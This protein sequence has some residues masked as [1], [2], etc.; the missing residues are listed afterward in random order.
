MRPISKGKGPAQLQVLRVAIAGTPNSGKTTLFNALTGTH[1]ETGN[2]P[3]V[4][5]EKKEGEFTTD[6]VRVH[7]VDLPGVYG[8]SAYTTDE[9]I[10]RDFLLHEHPDAVIVVVDATNLTQG[11]LLALQ[12]LQLRVPT[13]V[14]LNMMDQAEREGLEIHL[15][16]LERFLGVPVVPVVAVKGRGLDQLKKRLLEVVNHLPPEPKVPV[17]PAF[18]QVRQ[19]LE[20]LLASSPLAHRYPRSWLAQRLLVEDPWA[21]ALV[22]RDPVYPQVRSLLDQRLPELRQ[23]LGPD[24]EVYLVEQTYALLHGLV[25]RVVRR[26]ATLR[27]RLL[28]TQRVDRILLSPWFGL[29][30]FAVVMALTFQA[31]FQLS[32]PL[33]DAIGALFDLLGQGIRQLLIQTPIPPWITSLL[34][35][36]ILSGLASILTFVPPIFLLF[37]FIAFFENTGYMA[38]VAFVMDRFMHALGISGKSFI[39]MVLGFG[40]NVPAIM[41]TR[42][43]ESE[44]DRLITILVIPLMSCSARLPIYVLFASVFFPGREPVVVLSLYFLGIV[45]ALVLIKVLQRALFHQ[46]E[47]ESF[48]MELP[49]YRMPYLRNILLYMWMRGRVF[50]QNAGTVIL[51]ASVVLW[52]LASLPPGVAYASPQSVL[53]RIGQLLAPILKPAGFGFAEA[54]IALLTGVMAKELVVGTLG[55]LLA[56]GSI[57]GLQHALSQYFTPV[58]AYAFLVMSLIY[59]PCIATVAVIKQ[60]TGSWKWAALEVAM[61]FSLGY[62]LAVLVYQLGRLLV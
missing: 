58:S 19:Q 26:K 36:G 39:P 24:L 3:G 44:K 32:A 22:Q 33:V 37:G 14:A 61:T 34:V 27:K 52:A 53:G 46:R 20:H 54:A 8:L 6:D 13:L 48:V 59:V 4:T 42:T 38:R 35:D 28:F 25:Q 62:L 12:I 7:L 49:P 47:P 55:T 10:A 30:L 21:L 18:E 56:G 16:E 23:K 17:D 29:P 60:E 40:C 2:W 57:E 45:L 9:R 43:L 1:Q 11:L 41:A 50:V 31:T 5:V 51:V 15:E